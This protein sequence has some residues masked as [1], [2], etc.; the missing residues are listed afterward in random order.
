MKKT[1]IKKDAEMWRCAFL[2]QQSFYVRVF[3]TEKP[4]WKRGEIKEEKKSQLLDRSPPHIYQESIVLMLVL[5]NY[6]IN[7]SNQSRFLDMTLRICL[8][9]QKN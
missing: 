3:V 2:L 1:V 5:I 8:Y 6:D 7:Y 9:T 4:N